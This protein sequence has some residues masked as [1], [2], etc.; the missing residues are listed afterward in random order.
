MLLLKYLAK[1]SCVLV[2]SVVLLSGASLSLNSYAS[3]KC[4]KPQKHNS[5]K[6]N[7]HHSSGGNCNGFMSCIHICSGGILNCFLPV[8]ISSQAGD[9]SW[10]LSSEN[11]LFY[12]T[13]KWSELLTKVSTGTQ[14]QQ[15]EF[16]E[17]LHR[18]VGDLRVEI[19]KLGIT[20]ELRPNS[21]QL[22]DFAVNENG[23]FVQGVVSFM[24][25]DVPFQGQLT[26][27]SAVGS[28]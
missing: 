19:Q 13:D 27:Y 21:I 28:P 11:A 16:N 26:N 15:S 10:Q 3:V 24:D 2:A 6:G 1:Q 14:D 18:F 5:S 8:D 22:E 20:A 7:E 17:N 9:P 12:R 4:E 25:F 23:V